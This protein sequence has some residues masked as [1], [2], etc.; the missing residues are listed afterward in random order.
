M[1]REFQQRIAALRSLEHRIQPDEVWIQATRKTLRMQV[2]NSMPAVPVSS[3]RF[4]RLSFQDLIPTRL[5]EYVRGPVLA[6]LSVF[7]VAFGGS[8]ASV[9]AAEQSLPGDFLYNLK[10]ATEQARLAFTSDKEDKLTLKIEFTARRVEELKSVTSDDVPARS[11]RVVQ[12]AEL[13]KRD[14]NTVKQQLDDAK[15]GTKSDRLVAAAKLIDQ[16]SA[17]A[18]HTL[19]DSKAVLSN[20]AKEK[21]TEA[22][23]AAADTGVKAIEVLVEKHQES[24]DAVTENDVVQAI[25]E[26]SKTVAD[27]TGL[28]L[29]T[30][31]TA[32][33]SI[34]G[35]DIATSG[36]INVVA[37]TGT[38]PFAEALEQMKKST[39]NAFAAQKIIDLTAISAENGSS[40]S[41]IVPPESVTSSFTSTTIGVQ[42]SPFV[43]STT[44]S[45]ATA[46][47]SP[48]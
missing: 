8:V 23:A 10:L 30:S 17:K 29:S 21:V 3:V 47:T 1:S 15:T 39:Q 18:V 37:G 44:S 26:H 32:T 7:L 33:S 4:F 48:P 36:T 20:E 5:I 42:A 14:L 27:V 25:Q 28:S 46:T 35:V 34:S 16:T 41:G 24:G 13:L 12:A 11:A 38:L 22:Q 31:S 43:T 2:Q 40:T 45:T 9:S 19:Q 6:T